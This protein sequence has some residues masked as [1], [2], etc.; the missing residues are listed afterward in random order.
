MQ[1]PASRPDRFIP[2]EKAPQTTEP[3]RVWNRTMIPR[4]PTHTTVTIPTELP[5][6]A[7]EIWLH[8]KTQFMVSTAKA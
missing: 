6:L 8:A 4:N 1:Q 5:R 3:K 7:T 2:W